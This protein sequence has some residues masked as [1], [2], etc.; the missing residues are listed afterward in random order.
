MTT[1]LSWCLGLIDNGQH[2]STNRFLFLVPH[3]RSHDIMRTLENFCMLLPKALKMRAIKDTMARVADSM[4][5]TK[6]ASAQL[7]WD[8][9]LLNPALRLP[10]RQGM[11]THPNTKHGPELCHW[12]GQLIVGLCAKFVWPCKPLQIC[13]KLGNPRETTTRRDVQPLPNRHVSGQ[14]GLAKSKVID[15]ANTAT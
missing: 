13:A 10:N 3:E 2:K 1:N 7:S 11:S 9:G 5:G 6:C 15:F 8:L 4:G 12:K 14:R